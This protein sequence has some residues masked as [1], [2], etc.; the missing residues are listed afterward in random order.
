MLQEIPTAE[1]IKNGYKNAPENV[2]IF[3]I[4]SL[5]YRILEREFPKDI[6]FMRK[7]FPPQIFE[8]FIKENPKPSNPRMKDEMGL[9]FHLTQ[10]C[11]CLIPHFNFQKEK[12]AP[13]N[14]KWAVYLYMA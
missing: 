12:R 11:G 7:D 10:K 8:G 14:Y 6:G 13:H 2:K 9:P 4:D 3:H 1:R 5:N